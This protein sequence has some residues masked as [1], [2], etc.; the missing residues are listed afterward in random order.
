MGTYSFANYTLPRIY[1]S[2]FNLDF[3]NIDNTDVVFNDVIESARLVNI[4]IIGNL[5]NVNIDINGVEEVFIHTLNIAGITVTGK[6]ALKI[7]ES[8]KVYVENFIVDNVNFVG[9]SLVEFTNIE[10]LTIKNF[11]VTNCNLDA[12]SL[13]I[14]QFI[15]I[16][17]LDFREITVTGNTYAGDKASTFI[18]SGGTEH[19]HIS[20]ITFNDNVLLS[21]FVSKNFYDY[22][23]KTITLTKDLSNIET[24]TFNRNTMVSSLVSFTGYRITVSGLTFVDN[25]CEECTGAAIY[26]SDC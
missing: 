22:N 15:Q 21:F 14:V 20:D 19:S 2:D 16:F 9:G 7:E 12:D 1:L 24:G 10:Y 8:T 3:S 6:A 13:K 26:F 18:Y 5:D 11:R 23:K 25:E 4:N 17:K